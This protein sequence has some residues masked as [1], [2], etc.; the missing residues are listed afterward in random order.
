MFIRSALC[1]TAIATLS[2]C[3]GPGGAFI[4]YQGQSITY[5]STEIMP[6]TV[7]IRDLRSDEIVFTMEVPAGKQLTFQFSEGDGDDPVYTPD[8]MRYEVFD[9]G[10]RTGSLSSAMSVP[11]YWARRI[12]VYF[13]QG[14]EYTAASPEQ[15]LRTDQAAD[16]PDWWTSR[17]GDRPED[18]HGNRIY[19]E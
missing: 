8:L 15:A 4:P 11:P 18:P 12:D 13:R 2:A 5:E 1:F 3:H 6:K 16:R 10:T 14:P 17:G 7:Q 9:I 19:D